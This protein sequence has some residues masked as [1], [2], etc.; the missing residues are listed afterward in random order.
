MNHRTTL[1]LAALGLAL[2]FG[3]VAA[4][5]ADEPALKPW[6]FPR[7]IAIAGR[8]MTLAEPTVLSRDPA[9]GKVQ[10]RFAAK[11]TDPIG[12]E[13]WGVSDCEGVVH[14]D[15]NSRL[16]TVTDVK[17]GNALQPQLADQDREQVIPSMPGVF[18]KEFT[19]R[20][21]LLTAGPQPAPAAGTPAAPTVKASLLGPELIVRTSP[22]MLVQIDGDPVF[23]PVAEFPI[24]Y[25]INSMSDIF[26]DPKA[27]KCYL[28]G[29]GRWFESK[30]VAGPWTPL[31][32]SVPIMLSQIPASH[33]RAHILRWIPGSQA[34]AKAKTQAPTGTAPEVI[35]RDKPAELVIV[36]GEPLLTWIPGTKLMNV[37]NTESDLFFHPKSNAY[38]LTSGGRW[39]QADDV[40]GPWKEA[41]GALPDDFKSIPRDHPRGHVVWC[42]PGTPEAAEAAARAL[43]EEKASLGRAVNVEIAYE[44]K[45]P[46]NVPIEGADL[47][48]VTNSEDDIFKAEGAYWCCAR[49]VWLR[50]DDGKSQWKPATKLPAAI[51]AIPE[52]SGAAHVRF[53]R[54]LGAAE[55]GTA[56]SVTGGYHG[57]FFPNG[58]PVHGTGQT[59][60]G[61]QRNGNWY[62]YPKTFGENR[63]YDPAAGMFQPRTVK[64]DAEGRPVA[65]EWSPYTASYGRIR[66]F[67]DRYAMGGRRMFPWQEGEQRLD[68]AAPRPDIYGVWGTSIKS[69]DGIALDKLPLG[70]RA[71]ETSQKAP[72]VV[73]D[74]KGA[75][76]RQGE[77]S[78]ETWDGKAWVAKDGAGEDVK[79]WLAVMRRLQLRP[80]QWKTWAARRMAPL[81]VNSIR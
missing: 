46:E 77:K 80:D 19:L 66:H 28:L 36:A 27:G 31:A 42:V 15:L 49:G 24:E 41:L 26:R 65:A 45:G 61:M 7:D 20:L 62:A 71:A 38:F 14:L 57:V 58:S 52:M 67:A 11:I 12:R 16:F 30:T 78:L 72:P 73:A 4:R 74:E 81:P 13:F 25:V 2:A 3:P 51:E 60:R 22:A 1:S 48:Q 17:L 50:S 35:V 70:D 75:A 33:P 40:T 6:E 63:W 79:T 53:C 21:E 10:L 29:D 69:R 37:A 32:G 76:W 23:Q 5:A 34:Y 44:G 18:P 9:T 56:F 64:Y 39:F 59:R 43:L 47:A 8:R 54:P 68:T 55:D